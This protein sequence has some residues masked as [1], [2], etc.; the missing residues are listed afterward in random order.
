MSNS[1]Y[2]NTYLT[3][4]EAADFLKSRGFYISKKTLEVYA[5]RGKGPPYHKWGKRCVYCVAVLLEWAEGR[6]TPPAPTAIEHRKTPKAASAPTRTQ[7]EASGRPNRRRIRINPEM[8]ARA[9]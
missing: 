4:T 9:S 5:T 8:L 3:R 7:P 2:A 6:L 1:A